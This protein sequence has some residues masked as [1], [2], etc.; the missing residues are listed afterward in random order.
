MMKAFFNSNAQVYISGDLHYHDAKDV[1]GLNRGL[2]DVGHFASEHLIVER[3]VEDLHKR[4]SEKGMRVEIASCHKEK[5]PF[6]YV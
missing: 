6:E 1:T 2:I 3:L 5:D 4:F